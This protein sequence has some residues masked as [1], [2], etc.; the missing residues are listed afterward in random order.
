MICTCLQAERWPKLAFSCIFAI[1]RY[2]VGSV[3][4]SGHSVRFR[5]DFEIP[6]RLS[7]QWLRI[8]TPYILSVSQRV[9]GYFACY[10]LPSRLSFTTRARLAE[11][12]AGNAPEEASRGSKRLPPFHPHTRQSGIGETVPLVVGGISS[13]PFPRA[14]IP[15]PCCQPMS[16]C[17]IPSRRPADS[18]PL[19]VSHLVFPRLP[20]LPHR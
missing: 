7:F 12:D 18:N 5:D 14:D 15:E 19:F 2:C 9:T 10:H 16:R 3:T 13:G 8:C 11:F 20:R 1:R 4:P 17:S 6:V